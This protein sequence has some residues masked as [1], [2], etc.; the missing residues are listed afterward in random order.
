MKVLVCGSRSIND[1]GVVAEAMDLVPT[2]DYT[3]IHGGA[4]GVDHLAGE[5]AARRGLRVLVFKPDWAKYGKAAGYKRNIL[6]VN[7]AD[8]VI[9]VW[10]GVSKGTQ[11]SINYARKV[12]KP[13]IV[14]LN[15]QTS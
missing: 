13:V 5:V 14:H 12:D 4:K 3:V 8:M 6:M 11:H 9:A 1:I 7:E 10:D 2:D 15:K